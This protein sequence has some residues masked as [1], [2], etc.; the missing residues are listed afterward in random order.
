MSLSIVR[1]ILIAAM[2]LSIS[3]CSFQRETWKR[4]MAASPNAVEAALRSDKHYPYLLDVD[5]TQSSKIMPPSNLRP[6][7]AFGMDIKP[8]IATVT[9]P[10]YRV[11]NII[12]VASVGP[13]TYDAGFLGHGTDRQV[14]SNENNG[15]LYS[16]EGGFLDT[17]HI[18]DYSDWTVFL[19]TWI[20][21]NQAQEVELVLSPEVGSRPLHL[22]AYDNSQLSPRQQKQLNIALAQWLAFQVSVWHEIAQWHG[23]AVI[24]AFPEYASAYSVEDL[25]SNIIGTQIAGALI[26]GHAVST[27]QLYSRN[28]DIWLSNTLQHL[29]S[30]SLDQ[31]RAYMKG[32]DQQWWDSDAKLPEKFVVLK[33]N[34][35]VSVKQQAPAYPTILKSK[36]SAEILQAC[37][38]AVK[39]R[40]MTLAREYEGFQLN[41]LASLE[42]QILPEYQASF[43]YPTEKHR[44]LNRVNQSDF[45]AIAYM[46]RAEDGE[47]LSLHIVNN[48]D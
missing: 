39:P 5:R 6:C 19:Y 46:N 37:P 8:S 26:A 21:I 31:S 18:R 23:L 34:Y 27:D 40:V 10:F 13:H 47:Q 3:A 33:R 35:N 44:A 2:L 29:H 43:S 38:E 48:A 36:L 11:S 15:L 9:I 12:D 42:I 30:L 16:C 17:A 41:E 32:L 14:A 7:C 20:L 1:L 24:D 4:T 45:Q 25:Y 28:M 22:Q